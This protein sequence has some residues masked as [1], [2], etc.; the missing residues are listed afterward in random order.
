VVKFLTFLS[1]FSFDH[2][3]YVV[4]NLVIVYNV[5]LQLAKLVQ[6]KLSCR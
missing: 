4:C 3:H 5:S 1:H 6:Q 2:S